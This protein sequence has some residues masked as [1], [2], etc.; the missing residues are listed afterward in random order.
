MGLSG[1]APSVNGSVKRM[2]YTDK[3]KQRFEALIK[4]AKTLGEVQKLEKAYSEG[5]LPP[6]IADEDAMDET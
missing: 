3:E 6:G 1:A 4:K 5:R 2:K